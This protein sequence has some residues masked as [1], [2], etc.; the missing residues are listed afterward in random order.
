MIEYRIFLITALIV[1]L[2]NGVLNGQ[3]LKNNLVDWLELT[4]D[5]E[6]DSVRICDI[7][8][9]DGEFRPFTDENNE[10]TS[11]SEL[12][13]INYINVPFE[14]FPQKQCDL[15]IL[16][17][18]TKQQGEREKRK[19]LKAIRRELNSNLEI[20][21]N[22]RQCT[23]C[24]LISINNEFY[25]PYDGR[26]KINSMKPRQV[27]SIVVYDKPMNKALFSGRGQ[28]GLIVIKMK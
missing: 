8:S 4:Y 6:V 26:K 2:P 18:S 3:A 15:I 27:E 14:V 17:E 9:I 20:H 11:I 12:R 25:W 1:I 10:T 19:L 7:Y 13:S 23:P 5:L 28:N 21:K 22:D 24:K 16:V